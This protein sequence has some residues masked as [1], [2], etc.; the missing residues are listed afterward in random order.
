MKNGFSEE[1]EYVPDQWDHIFQQFDAEAIWK[2]EKE[3][4]ARQEEEK[5]ITAAVREILTAL[6][7]I[8]D[9]G[10]GYERADEV[11]VLFGKGPRG[12][13]GGDPEKFRELNTYTK[14]PAFLTGFKE[15]CESYEIDRATYTQF[16]KRVYPG[17]FS[18]VMT[19]MR[20]YL[21]G[22]RRKAPYR[23][24]KKLKM[25]IPVLAIL[26]IISYE[27]GMGTPVLYGLLP[28]ALVGLHWFL[29]RILYKRFGWA[30]TNILLGLPALIILFFYGEHVARQGIIAN[31]IFVV[32]SY[33][34]SFT[35]IALIGLLYR[36]FMDYVESGSPKK[37][38][39]I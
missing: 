3:K 11:K 8:L 1:S 7:A 28:A 23:P 22:K 9:R 35:F 5:R 12:F 33:Y 31:G 14:D 27:T 21:I 32:T 37:R 39:K 30:G 2:E 17:D 19:N 20:I 15:I 16:L 10:P 29:Y 4:L 24:L 26:L 36:L 13:S 25:Y 34:I 6:K 18:D 38:E